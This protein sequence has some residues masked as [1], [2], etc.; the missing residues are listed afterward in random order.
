M[1]TI[2]AANFRVCTSASLYFLYGIRRLVTS[3]LDPNSF[4]SSSTR[5]AQ[6]Q[7]K[8]VSLDIPNYLL[9]KAQV[10][11]SLHDLCLLDYIDGSFPS[12]PE[13]TSALSSATTTTKDDP[14]SSF[15][16]ALNLEYIACRKKAT[17]S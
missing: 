10:F 14:S 16:I 12:P 3:C 4:I 2:C 13:Y 9:W 1:Y 8:H 6:I 15:V 7:L 17:D 5:S 11:S